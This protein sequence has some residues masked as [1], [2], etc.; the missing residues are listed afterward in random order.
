MSVYKK[1]SGI[2]LIE[3]LLVIGLVSILAASATP[4]LSRF[5]QQNNLE[6]TTDYTIGFL[7][8][9]QMY[10]MLGKN[11]AVWGVCITGST[12]RLYTGTCSEPIIHDDY[13]IPPR[14]SI[15]GLTDV[16]F[17]KG[18]G[19]PVTPVSITITSDLGVNT[20]SL[21]TAGGMTI[22]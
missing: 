17:T 9:A 21:N 8:K 11:D 7:R 12:L 20:M 2:T 14:I 19:E 1:Q 6:V 13:T 5:I 4:F 15:T 16:S 22:N 3:V 18:R 10:T